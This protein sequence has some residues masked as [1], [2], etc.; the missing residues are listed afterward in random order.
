MFSWI[1][2]VSLSAFVLKLR[3]PFTDHAI[4]LHFV[5]EVTF[6]LATSSNA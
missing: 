6:S 1:E 5:I 4:P 2:D 3:K